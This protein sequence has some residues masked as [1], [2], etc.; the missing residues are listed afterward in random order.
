MGLRP[1]LV[2]GCPKSSGFPTHLSFNLPVLSI[3]CPLGVNFPLEKL[4]LDE[5]HPYN[6]G[7]PP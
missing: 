7:C 4:F 3:K 6:G 2:Y 1:Y 5:P